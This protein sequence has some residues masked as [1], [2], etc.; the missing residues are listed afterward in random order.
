MHIWIHISLYIY[1]ILNIIQ[2]K[3]LFKLYNLIIL[4]ISWKTKIQV[5]FLKTLEI[6]LLIH[7]FKSMIT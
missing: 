6:I 3:L 5:T 2:T 1:L 7:N 4:E